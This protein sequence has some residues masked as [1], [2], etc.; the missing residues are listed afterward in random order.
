MA[1]MLISPIGNSSSSVMEAQ[2]AIVGQALA[3]K[4]SDRKDEKTEKFSVVI[5]KITEKDWTIFS[6][7][8]EKTNELLG[9]LEVTE[10]PAYENKPFATKPI[11]LVIDFPDKSNTIYENIDTILLQ[12]AIEWSL[13][14][15]SKGRVD[16]SSPESSAFFFFQ[17]GFRTSS[18]VDASH[19]EEAVNQDRARCLKIDQ[20]I[21]DATIEE[22]HARRLDI[23]RP[24]KDGVI[25]PKREN[26]LSVMINDSYLDSSH[27][28]MNL[29]EENLAAWKIKI[30]NNPILK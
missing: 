16:V 5:R 6:I 28:E 19:R 25:R 15:K 22:D 30:S 12:V 1:S 13:Q 11:R 14:N 8:L 20:L 9:K 27:I 10:F 18:R 4:T 29:T 26:F 2:N 7:Y 3:T 23:H 17:H 21:K 24:V